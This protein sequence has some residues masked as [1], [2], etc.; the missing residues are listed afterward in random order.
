MAH[1]VSKN[2]GRALPFFDIDKGYICG[3]HDDFIVGKFGKNDLFKTFEFLN[4]WGNPNIKFGARSSGFVL[5]L[6]K[7]IF[8]DYSKNGLQNIDLIQ[9]Y[10]IALLCEINHVYQP[11]SNG[12]QAKVASEIGIYDQS[13]FSRLFKKYEGVTPLLFRKMVAIS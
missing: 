7:R 12:R 9:S 6:L 13:Y 10:F 8:T 4:V 1:T 3:F 11:V 5:Q 2:Q